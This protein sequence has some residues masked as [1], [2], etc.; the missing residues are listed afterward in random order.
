MG[1]EE[2]S[3][4]TKIKQLIE[5]LVNF[6]MFDNDRQTIASEVMHLADKVIM[7]YTEIESLNADEQV[8]RAVAR[9]ILD[10]IREDIDR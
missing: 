1:V 4:Q 9:R 3:N 10:L 7:R 5:F 2:E 6:Q 8:M